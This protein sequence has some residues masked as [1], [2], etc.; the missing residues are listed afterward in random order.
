MSCQRFDR[1]PYFGRIPFGN[2]RRIYH[3]IVA[4]INFI[5]RVVKA[6]ELLPR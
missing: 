3:E 6:I 1:A 2:K 4:F 5:K